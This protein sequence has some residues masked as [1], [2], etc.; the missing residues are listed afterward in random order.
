MGLDLEGV[1]E[2]MLL[3]ADEERMEDVARAR[4][5]AAG[6]S[7]DK[8]RSGDGDRPALRRGGLGD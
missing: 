5:R 4:R 7:P 1:F 6:D 2:K 8:S 3:R